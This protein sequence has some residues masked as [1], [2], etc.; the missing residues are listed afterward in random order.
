M[1]EFFEWVGEFAIR[2]RNHIRIRFLRSTLCRTGGGLLLPTL[3]R[4]CCP[5][6]SILESM[7]SLVFARRMVGGFL[8]STFDRVL[9][10][11]V[12]APPL[13]KTCFEPIKGGAFTT[14]TVVPIETL[15]RTRR[16]ETAS[17]WKRFVSTRRGEGTAGQSGTD[18]NLRGLCRTWSAEGAGTFPR[19]IGYQRR[20]TC[21]ATRS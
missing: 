18:T 15:P 2:S 19:L 10:S 12:L 6:K 21:S 13:G 11:Q 7:Q 3:I 9:A 8:L 16:R 4:P 5:S 20:G 1:S 17:C 14:A